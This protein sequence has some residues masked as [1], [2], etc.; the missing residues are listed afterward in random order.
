MFS[1]MLFMFLFFIGFMAMFYYLLKKQEQNCRL[2]R[3]EHAQLRVLLRAVESR[4]DNVD[5]IQTLRAARDGLLDADAPENSGMEKE[6]DD[7]AAGHDPLLHLSFEE[8]AS[9][10]SRDGL[11]ID[12]EPGK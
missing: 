12:F 2:L 4:L 10:R 9:G 7:D 8:P 5:R 6:A 11:N 1:I 3:D